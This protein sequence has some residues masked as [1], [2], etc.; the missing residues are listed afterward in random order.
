M[1]YPFDTPPDKL[2]QAVAI[3]KAVLDNHEG[4]Q[5]DLPPQVHFNG[6]G[7]FS[8]KITVFAW[9]H[10]ADYWAFQNWLQTICLAILRRFEAEGIEFAFPSQTVYL[11][12]D[13]RRQ[14]KLAMDADQGTIK[15][16]EAI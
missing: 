8:L 9:Y 4:M 7:D 1:E 3:V 2:E 15:Q 13:D 6:F 16:G 5:A 12:N 11:A 14:L 10:P